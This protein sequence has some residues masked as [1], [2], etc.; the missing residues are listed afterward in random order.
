MGILDEMQQEQTLSTARTGISKSQRR[1]KGTAYTALMGAG[2]ATLPLI[3][4]LHLTKSTAGNYGLLFFL[5][6]PATVA[7]LSMIHE[8]LVGGEG[9]KGQEFARALFKLVNYS[10]AVVD[11][12]QNKHYLGF[13]GRLF[14]SWLTLGL[15]WT[16]AGVGIGAWLNGEIGADASMFLLFASVYIV[17]IGTALYNM[18]VYRITHKSFFNHE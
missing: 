14:I 8:P 2:L 1:L 6:Y 9:D 16:A 4:I 11:E 3:D 15:L 7:L 5:S 18:S 12:I 13:I 17:S 10:T